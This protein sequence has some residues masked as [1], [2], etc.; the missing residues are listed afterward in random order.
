MCHG[1]L[2]GVFRLVEEALEESRG[3]RYD[4]APQYLSPSVDSSIEGEL[5]RMYARGQ[6]SRDTFLR[7]RPSARQGELAWADLD[8][9]K[10]E[11]RSQPRPKPAPA[12]ETTA[13]LANIRDKK[14]ALQQAAS[15]SESVA[16]SLDQRISGSADEAARLESQAREVLPRD[17]GQARA[18]LMKRQEIIE[19]SG[20]LKERVSAL[21]EDIQ[22]LQ[23]LGVELDVREQELK[24]LQARERLGALEEEIKKGPQSGRKS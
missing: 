1:P 14:S 5:A 2:D 16:Q 11:A 8:N 12:V 9:L 15:D 7:L 6:I 22:R 20:E 18:L 10:R 19:R 13:A 17:E 4:A 24:I 3:H 21:R 23:D